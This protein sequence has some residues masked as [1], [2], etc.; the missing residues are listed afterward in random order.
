M[1]SLSPV[2]N[3]NGSRRWHGAVGWKLAHMLQTI[4]LDWVAIPSVC[5]FKL[6]V[7]PVTGSAYT[8]SLAD[9]SADETDDMW[10]PMSSF[11]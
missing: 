6:V 4:G 7:L 8:S 5:E 10:G 11:S 3:R 9:F 1:V 2:K